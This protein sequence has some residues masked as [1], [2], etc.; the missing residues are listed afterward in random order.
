MPGL[1]HGGTS[2]A[3]GTLLQLHPALDEGV[4]LGLRG[5]E[6]GGVRGG[7]LRVAGVGGAVGEGG[8]DR[9][10]LALER[11]DAAGQRRQLALLVEA[12]ARR[13][14]RGRGPGL[15]RPRRRS[16]GAGGAERAPPRSSAARSRS[17]SLQ[18]PGQTWTRPPPS[19]TK[20]DV[21]TW[22]MK[23]RSWLTRTSVPL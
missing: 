5:G 4:E 15:R 19:S 21:A 12:Q 1:S 20:Q 13:P 14:L 16:G 7:A 23:S 6:A 10:D 2:A 11:G 17:Q 9:G 18:P 22:S 3:G 8:L